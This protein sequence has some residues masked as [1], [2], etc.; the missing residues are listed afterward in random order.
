[1][2]SPVVGGVGAAAAAALQRFQGQQAERARENQ[3]RS[4]SGPLPGPSPEQKAAARGGD[5]RPSGQYLESRLSG[6]DPPVRKLDDAWNPPAPVAVPQ[7]TWEPPQKELH[8]SN[9]LPAHLGGEAERPPAGGTHR[10]KKNGWSSFDGDHFGGGS[11]T[12]SPDMFS[13][14]F[15]NVPQ[16]APSGVEIAASPPPLD[17]MSLRPRSPP[18]AWG[19]DPGQGAGFGANGANFGQ[20]NFQGAAPNLPELSPFTSMNLQANGGEPLRLGQQTAASPPA[21]QFLS[22]QQPYP[23]NPPFQQQFTL[24]QYQ[25]QQAQFPQYQQAPTAL[26]P[27]APYQ[28]QATTPPNQFQVPPQQQFQLPPPTYQQPATPP[29]QQYVA[30]VQYPQQFQQPFPQAPVGG[31]QFQQAMQPPVQ[32]A[33]AAGGQFQQAILPPAPGAPLQ[34]QVVQLGQTLRVEKPPVVEPPWNQ[35]PQME[36]V[37][38]PLGGADTETDSWTV[39]GSMSE[40]SA[41]ET[42]GENKQNKAE[43]GAALQKPFQPQLPPPVQH[44]RSSSAENRLETSLPTDWEIPFAELTLGPKIGQVSVRMYIR[45][46]RRRIRRG[47]E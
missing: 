9:T 41:W 8:W 27:H 24:P 23:P 10:G 2:G 29:Q 13:P 12:A 11:G 19:A 16:R 14:V 20:Q 7:R 28:Q 43:G 5:G 40:S 36:T 30:P 15:Q 39:P 45:I 3:E 6:V 44:R 47:K 1:M 35:K 22:P 21:Q 33:P 26:S 38:S 32:V 37:A 18:L 42:F 4:K 25:P 46:V 31:G 34:Q 17:A